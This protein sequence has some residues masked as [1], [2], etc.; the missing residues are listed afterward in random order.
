[1]VLIVGDTTS[2]LSESFAKEHGV[3]IIP[4][5]ISFGRDSY[6]EGVDITYDSFMERLRVATELPKTAAPPPEL[7][8]EI[9]QRHG[10]TGDPIICVLPSASVSGTVRS[11]TVGLT[12]AR[13][14]GFPDLDVRIIDTNF[15]ASP[16]S[17]L[18]RLAVEWAE[19]GVDADAI[20]ARVR[21]MSCRCRI[22]FVVDTLKYLAMGGRIGGAAALLGSVL[23]VKPVLTMREG[24]V[25]TL[26]KVRT[27]KRAVDRLKLLVT[28]QIARKESGYLTIMH[29]AAEA[30]AAGLRDSLQ[31]RLGLSDIPVQSVPPAVVTHG[32][33]GVL[34]VGFFVE[35]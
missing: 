34:G 27:H 28:E 25:D 3:P 24:Q 31:E 12:I 22:Y 4:Q 14:S 26:E 13:E 6:F 9:F 21:A 18:L 30:E 23:Q 16:V 7:F 17:T 2:G 15:I 33:P 35:A 5:I 19:A 11:A 10:P 8:A 20:E 32:G 1:M 29:A